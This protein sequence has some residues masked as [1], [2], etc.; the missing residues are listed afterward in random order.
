[1][2]VVKCLYQPTGY[3]LSWIMPFFKSAMPDTFLDHL[4]ALHS[5]IAIVRILGL[6]SKHDGGWHT[7]YHL[8][9]PYGNRK[10]DYNAFSGHSDSWYLVSQTCF[11]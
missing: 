7:T 9:A 2:A 4:I 5:Q 11:H 6:V 10:S 3:L 8:S 1:M